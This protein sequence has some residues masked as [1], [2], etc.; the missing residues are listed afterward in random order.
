MRDMKF[1]SNN[2]LATLV[3]SGFILM[4][5]FGAQSALADRFAE[6]PGNQDRQVKVFNYDESTQCNDDG[7]PLEEMQRQL[8]DAGIAVHCAQKGNDGNAYPA[9][10][11]G[12][13][14]DINIY[15]IDRRDVRLAKRLGFRPVSELENYQDK[16]CRPQSPKVFKY[17]GSTQ[18]NE[19]GIP[20]EK[21]KR[22]LM[23]AG[24]DVKCSQ[25][26]HDGL[27]YPAVCDGATGNINVYLIHPHNIPDAEKLGF[28]SVSELTDYQDQSC[29]HAELAR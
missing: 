14:G 3:L 16:P 2:R 23:A 11:G 7:I 27:L 29:P 10:C 22:K 15:L 20:L 21:M 13:S 28:R 17:D 4:L 26:A 8:T 24:N 6:N 9:V 18:C 1:T 25:K 5:A 19:D 12:A